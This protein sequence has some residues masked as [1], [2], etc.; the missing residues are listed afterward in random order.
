M[1]LVKKS[2]DGV[3]IRFA[4][5]EVEDAF[6]RRSA[7]AVVANQGGINGQR[8]LAV[9]AGEAGENLRVLF[10][11]FGADG[12]VKAVFENGGGVVGNAGSF[13]GE[14]KG[15]GEQIGGLWIERDFRGIVA[16]EKC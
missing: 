3:F 9:G 10:D 12:R 13:E 1:S 11:E 7:P 15:F 16:G 6:E 4:D 8:L 5:A 2:F 14:A